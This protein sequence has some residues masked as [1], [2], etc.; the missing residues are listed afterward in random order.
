[1]QQLFSVDSNG[2]IRVFRKTEL[3]SLDWVTK[4]FTLLNVP[5]A[6]FTL[7]RPAR[8]GDKNVFD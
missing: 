4:S 1:L 8:I 5:V 6:I 3:D 7:R 2:K